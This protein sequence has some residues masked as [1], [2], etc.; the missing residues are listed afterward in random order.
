MYP[1]KQKSYAGIF[2]KNQ[3]EE[4]QNII[5]NDDSLEIFY[6]KRAFTSKIGSLL[7]YSFAFV[8]FM[9]NLFK[10]FDIIHVH[11]FYPLILLAWLNKKLH[12]K[13]KIVVTFLGRDINSQV[14]KR[15]Q[16]FFRKIA[17]E[18]DFSIP[19][20]VT[21]SSQIKKKLDLDE[22][23]IIPCGVND[24]I[25]YKEESVLKVYDFIMVGSFIH[26]KGIDTVIKAIKL[27]PKNTDIKF[28]FCGSGN[29]L[30]ELENLQKDY[31]I[32]I[33]QNQTQNQL[34]ELLNASR[35]FLLMSRAE[36]F[37]TAT[38]EAFF[39]G[40]PV[41][42]SDIDNF[43]EQVEEGV[44]GY[45]SQLGNEKLLKEN[46]LKLK[47]LSAKKY[48]QLADGANTSFTSAS[49]HKVCLQIYEIYKNLNSAQ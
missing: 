27:L 18:V 4:L 39:C 14:N 35:F 28:C 45:T 37:A 21:L 15:N 9:P 6:M 8:R 20:G 46:F 26:R 5:S 41:L 43:K 12:K 3:F 13:T 42:T 33:K 30:V 47:S 36:G 44:N 24:R 34:R 2:I 16:F 49:L 31:N 32:T 17:N 1:S 11:Y 19:V 38:T 7:K 22:M 23:K 10:R 29:Y 25:F 48:N 40:V